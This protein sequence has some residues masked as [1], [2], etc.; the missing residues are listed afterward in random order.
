MIRYQKT[1]MEM[2]NDL[3]QCDNIEEFIQKNQKNFLDTNAV[4]FLESILKEKGLKKSDVIRGSGLNQVYAY[5]IFSGAKHADR[6]KLICIAIAAKMTGDEADRL[7]VAEHKSPFYPRVLRD[8]L[9][10]YALNHG[11]SVAQTDDLLYDHD[12]KTLLNEGRGRPVNG[13]DVLPEQPGSHL[14]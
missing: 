11:Y 2:K 13:F 3:D 1:T 6:D 12:C 5:Q 9:I 10:L 7:L 4:L 8:T 14:E